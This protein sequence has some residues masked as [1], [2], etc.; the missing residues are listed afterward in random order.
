MKVIMYSAITLDGFI[1]DPDGQCDDWIS[2][3]DE[4]NYEAAVERAGCVLMGRTTYDQYR[5]ELS[6]DPKR[7]VFVWTRSTELKDH[8]NVKYLRGTP[9]EI[10]RQIAEQDFSELVVS[11]GGEANGALAEAGLVN[12]MVISIYNVVLGEGI[13]LFGSHHPQLKLKL[14]GTKQEIEGLVTNHYIASMTRG[15]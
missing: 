9:E 15:C 4:K 1:A 7:T 8:D 6:T 14:L 10:I 12:E 3:Q 5:D 13:R 11:G 2:E